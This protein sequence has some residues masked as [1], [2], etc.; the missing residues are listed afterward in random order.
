MVLHD[1]V[2]S[3]SRPSRLTGGLLAAPTSHTAHPQTQSGW[4][5]HDGRKGGV[6]R[7]P[8]INGSTSDNSPCIYITSLIRLNHAFYPHHSHQHHP[9]HQH[10]QRHLSA[11]LLTTMAS[12]L[13]SLA[14]A[15]T[16]LAA[17]PS[18][19]AGFTPGSS[20]NVAVYWGM[21]YLHTPRLPMGNGY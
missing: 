15:A 19:L 16:L 21:S 5:I 1:C 17:L 18:V 11:F 3:V 7:M 9:P 10:Q 13:R 12:S 6:S 20:S 14:S 4:T 8:S 2:R